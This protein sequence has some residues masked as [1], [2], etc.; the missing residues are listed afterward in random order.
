MH[1]FADP[2]VLAPLALFAGSTSGASAQARREA[3]GRGA[4]PLQALAFAGGMLALLA[5]LVSPSTGSARTTSSRRTW[6]STCC[7]A[8]SRRCCCCWRSRA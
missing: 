2:A 1:W 6:S 8:T 5:A 7:S 4:G 3:G